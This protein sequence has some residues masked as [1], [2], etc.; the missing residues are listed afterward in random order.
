MQVKTSITGTKKKKLVISSMVGT[1]WKIIL[2][3]YIFLCNSS[4]N[5]DFTTKRCV[6]GVP[7]HRIFRCSV[8]KKKELAKPLIFGYGAL[9]LMHNTF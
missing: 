8:K 7:N 5:I 2:L 6:L 4:I 9:L 3:L 1:E